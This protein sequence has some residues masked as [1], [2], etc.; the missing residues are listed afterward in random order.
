MALHNVTFLKDTARSLSRTSAQ[1]AWGS[2]MAKHLP[3]S[4]ALRRFLTRCLH[5]GEG[6]AAPP[7][8]HT[9]GIPNL[10]A[11][12]CGGLP[13]GRITL[14]QG[15]IAAGKTS[16]CLTLT[17]HAQQRR[18]MAAWLDLDHTL[19]AARAQAHGLLPSTLAARC[20]DLH[21]ALDMALALLQD[22]A[23]TW[24]VLDPWPP[25]Q[26]AQL[27]RRALTAL[28]RTAAKT[29]A[30]VL[31]TQ[32]N[33]DGPTDSYDAMRHMASTKLLLQPAQHTSQGQHLK[34]R[35]PRPTRITVT[36]PAAQKP[37]NGSAQPTF[38]LPF[39]W[40]R[41]YQPGAAANN[42]PHT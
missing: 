17:A 12:L 7:K 40:D 9:T 23:V 37:P 30:V 1:I 13:P 16:L 6:P 2:H 33:I 5:L 39:S 3:D 24:L 28:G 10:D 32:T 14:V 15:A 18:H 35:D 20:A 34:A 31:I 19:Q 36:K 29:G 8:R 11:A 41:G 27:P 42:W 38:I 26:M 4:A 21:Q 22:H 25:L